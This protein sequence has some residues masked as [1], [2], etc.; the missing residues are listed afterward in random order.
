MKPFCTTSYLAILAATAGLMLCAPCESRAQSASPVIAAG[1]AQSDARPFSIALD[2]RVLVRPNKGAQLLQTR[3]IAVRNGEAVQAF[4]QQSFSYIEGMQSLDIVEAYTEKPDKTRIQVDP[5][6]ILNQDTA[7]GLAA[8]YTHDQK[9]KTV[10]FPDVQP[11]DT[12]VVT[13][14]YEVK[15]G[16]FPGKFTELLFYSRELPVDPSTARITAPNNIDLH[17]A[18]YGEGFEH[19]IERTGSTTTYLITYRPQRWVA[20][21]ADETSPL[22]RDPRVVISTFKDYEELGRS[23]WAAASDKVKVTGDI[24]RLA[25]EITKGITDRR[26]QAEAIDR[27]IKRNVRYVGL[28]LGNGRWVPHDAASVLKNKYGDCKDHATLMIALLA[29]KRIPAEYVLINLGNVYTLPDTVAPNYFNHA[30]VYV[31]EFDAY[32]DPTA[33]TAAFGVL[34]R[35]AYDKPVL[36]ASA[37]GAKLAHTPAMRPEEHLSTNRTHITIAAD[38]TISGETWQVTTGANATEARAAAIKSGGGEAAA[39]QLLQWAGNPGKGRLEIGSPM[40][41]K[42]PY[43]AGGKFVLDARMRMPLSGRMPIPIGMPVMTRPGQFLL[44]SRLPT[45]KAPFMCFAGHQVEE[46]DVTMEEGLPMPQML[47]GRF[48]EDPNFTY[49][50]SYQIE[51]R[52]LKVRREFISRVP[53]QVCPPEIEQGLA[54]PLKLIAENLT[55]TKLLFPNAVA[56]APQRT[57]R[58]PE[59]QPRSH[60]VSN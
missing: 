18:L 35:Q 54:A 2:T 59:E 11:G 43:V 32:D 41:L 28:Y 19:R 26:A 29:A 36:R 58:A 24:Q 34:A 1:E 40:E 56:K 9:A 15:S 38:G 46:I 5:A 53:G 25:D 8:V 16:M 47:K 4:G 17:L 22:D 21:E 27:W 20:A 6:T 13:T 50:T 60:L 3:R 33:G 55:N 12:L 52:T 45:R 42:E 10:I 30:I 49:Q 39:A 37:T 57:S 44:G 48:M 51:G 23:V 31:P 7:S 14:R